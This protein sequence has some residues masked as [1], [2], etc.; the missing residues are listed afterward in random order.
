MLKTSK[1]QQS[2]PLRYVIAE[3]ARDNAYVENKLFYKHLF[4]H[5]ILCYCCCGC[6][7]CCLPALILNWKI[8]DATQHNGYAFLLLVHINIYVCS[9]CC[10]YAHTHKHATRPDG[11]INTMKGRRIL[12]AVVELDARRSSSIK[13]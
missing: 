11:T 2:C 12:C 4:S 1:Q 5:K 9:I 3:Y 8:Y 10:T 13:S 7:C 6:C